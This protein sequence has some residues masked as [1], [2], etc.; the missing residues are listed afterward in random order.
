MSHA[1][2]EIAAAPGLLLTPGPLTT[3][4][5]TR[6]AM[7]RDWGSRDHDFIALT[8]RLRTRLA[9]LC[10]AEEGYSCVPLQ[11]S[12]TF[13]VEAMIASLVPADGHLL[14]A[15]NGAYGRRIATIAAR[16]GLRVGTVDSPEHLPTDVAALGAAL[17][18]GRFSHLAAVHC[19]TTSGVLNPL[20]EIAAMAREHRVALLVDSMSAFGA[21]AIDAPGLAIEA[22]AGSANKCL[23]GVP[24]MAFVI[25]REDALAAAAGRCASLSLDLNDQWQAFENNGQWR[26]TPPTHVIA[27]LDAALDQLDA[28]GGVA[29]RGARYRENCRRLVSGMRRLGFETLLADTDQAPIIVTFRMPDWP[30]FA[31]APFYDG[32]HRRGFVIYPG[33]VTAAESFR[34]GCIGAIAPA[35]ID[36]AVA[37]VAATLESL[38]VPPK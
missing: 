25:A 28:E 11:G 22:L 19:E 35:D 31:F 38:G 8:A 1:T 36:A 24:G 15:V 3:T 4:A 6:A 20:A 23:E 12:G 18:G 16:L 33:K 5:L 17:D 10:G 37:A 21:V 29:A 14:V 32:L 27:A 7:N 30:G 34:I 9:A 26:F 13:A 2:D